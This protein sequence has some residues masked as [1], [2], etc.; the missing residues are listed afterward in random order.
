M[1]EQ[2][3]DPR[4]DDPDELAARAEAGGFWRLVPG[5]VP[6]DFTEPTPALLEHVESGLRRLVA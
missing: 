1:T 6:R 5:W 2:A 3:T 4:L